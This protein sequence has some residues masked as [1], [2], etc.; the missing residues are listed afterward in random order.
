[1]DPIKDA[2]NYLAAEVPK[3]PFFVAFDTE[4]DLAALRDALASFAVLRISDFCPTSDALPDLDALFGKLNNTMGKILLLGVGEYAAL[5]GRGD[6]VQTLFGFSLSRSR[7][8]VPLWRGHVFLA[9]ATRSDPRVMGRRGSAFPETGH[10]WTANIFRKGLV[11]KTDVSGFRA[12][13]RKLETGCDDDLS[14]ITAVV[15]LETDWCRKIESAYMVYKTRHPQSQVPEGMFSENTWARFLDATRIAD[16]ALWSAD[17]F[18]AFLEDGTDDV[19]LQFALS[20][21]ERF[22]DW[23]RNILCAIL[24]VPPND[25]RFP[26][27]YE[28]RKK[29]ISALEAEDMEEFLQEARIVADPSVRLRYMTDATEAERTEIVRLVVE[30]GR[31]PDGIESVYPALG[32]YLQDF[33]FSPNGD[34]AALLTGYVRDYKRQKMLNR[35]EPVFE[36]RVGDLSE[37]R[38]QFVLPTRESVLEGLDKDG[39]VL[40][41]MDALGCEYLGFIRAAAERLRLKFKVTPVRVKLPSLTSV[42]RGFFDGWA[43]PKMEKD[44]RVD[45]IKHGEFP[46]GGSKEFPAHLPYE[47]AALDEGMKT[48]AAQL[49]KHPGSKVVLASDHGATRLAVIAAR[50]TVW[51]MP[52]KGKHG[53]RCCKKSEFDGVLPACVTESDDEAW[54]VLAGY[55]RFKGGRKGDVEVH[56]GATLEEMVVPVV[57]LELLDPNLRVRLVED[58]F[59]VTFRDSEITLTLFCTASLSSPAVEVGNKRYLAKA[60]GVGSGRYVV[61]VPKPEAGEHVAGVFDGDTKVGEVH[62]SVTSGGAQIKNDDFF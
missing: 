42:N 24:D 9:S 11:D 13:M 40:C 36:A 12:L 47:L 8:V 20:K 1:M 37:D 53:G 61:R 30:A 32:D 2:N 25:E 18:L 62:F 4:S 33:A 17:R 54:H 39:A 41:W 55:D 52:E 46:G 21:T 27:F 6:F 29:T 26:R 22:S 51:E 58:R 34:F 28:A 59:K 15:P 57:E 14:V 31:I 49:R 16:D 23:R 43:G 10:H 3:T 44:E 35:V 60:D 45:S 50:E 56:G 7:V 38:P 19:Y 48:I 5:T